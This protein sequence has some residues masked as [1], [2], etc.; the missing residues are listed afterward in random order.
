VGNGDFLLNNDDLD[1]VHRHS[2]ERLNDV[3]LPPWAKSPRD[4]IKKHAK[5][6]GKFSR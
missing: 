1:L 6:L 5:A 3:D 2:G 4:F